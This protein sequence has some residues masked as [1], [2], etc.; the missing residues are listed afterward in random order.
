[1]DT[2]KLIL[3]FW[4]PKKLNTIIDSFTGKLIRKI[5]DWAFKGHTEHVNT[6]SKV[7]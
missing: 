7:F 6:N 1:M 3:W 5:A 4:T 2:D